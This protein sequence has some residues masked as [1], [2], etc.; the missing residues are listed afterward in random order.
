MVRFN[1]GS[2]RLPAVCAQRVSYIIYL[3]DDES[4]WT[5]DDGGALELYACKERGTPDASPSATLL[6]HFNRS[7]EV[8]GD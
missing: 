1:I 2:L 8:N 3:S 7:V 4:E 5:A 6:P